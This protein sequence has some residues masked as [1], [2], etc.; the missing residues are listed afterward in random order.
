MIKVILFDLDDTLCDYKGAQ[1]KA[2]TEI[3]VFLHQK[4]ISVSAFWE[5]FNSVNESLFQQYVS[6]QITLDNYR[7]ARFQFKGLNLSDIQYLNE[8]YMGYANENLTLFDDVL[9]VFEIL[10]RHKIGIAILTNG[11]A[12]GQRKK[13]KNLDLLKDDL[14]IFISSEVGSAK[15]SVSYY[16]AVLNSLNISPQEAV[17][18]GDSLENDYFGARRAGIDSLL[19]DRWQ[20]CNRSDIS[21]VRNLVEVLEYLGLNF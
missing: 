17:M 21:V 10:L 20:S 8:L 12:E 16:K 18:I 7:N 14:R 3:N 1:E 6:D 11:P 13:L 5:Q 9:P 2:K 15:P 19:L 4:N